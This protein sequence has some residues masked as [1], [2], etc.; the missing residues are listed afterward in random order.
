LSKSLAIVEKPEVYE[1]FS[2]R[3]VSIVGCGVAKLD[4]TVSSSL[5]GKR[6]TLAA[7]NKTI[8]EN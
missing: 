8:T 5:H 2:D 6:Y 1:A 3:A 7:R 4:W